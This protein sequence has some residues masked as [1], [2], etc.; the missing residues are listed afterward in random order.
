MKPFYCKFPLANGYMIVY[1]V[2]IW[3]TSPKFLSALKKCNIPSD[4]EVDCLQIVASSGAPLTPE[5]YTW[6]YENF[7]RRIG[8]WSGSG[9]TDLVGGSMW[10]CNRASENLLT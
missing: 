4:L 2:T 6:F 9:G 1:S 5:L 3:G 7:P 8:L 10:L